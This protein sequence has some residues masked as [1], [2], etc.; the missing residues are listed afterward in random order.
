MGS[1]FKM[2]CGKPFTKMSNM[3]HEVHTQTEDWDSRL[4][5]I[6]YELKV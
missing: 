4:E 1:S 5:E 6:E 2:S 3:R